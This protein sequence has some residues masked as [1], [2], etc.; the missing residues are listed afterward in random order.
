VSKIEKLTS[1]QEAQIPV[2][3]ERYLNYGLDTSRIDRKKVTPMVA[4]IY[5]SAGL[6]APELIL[7]FD[8][9]ASCLLAQGVLQ[10]V[11]EDKDQLGNQLRNQ[12]IDQLRNQ[13]RN[14]LWN[15]LWDQL[16]DPLRVQLR[17]QLGGQLG[18]QLGDQLRNQLWDQLRVQLR[19][20]LGGQLGNQL[21]DQLRNQLWDQLW[22]PLGDQLWNQLGDPL[23]NQLIDQLRNQ[24]GNQLR[25]QLG[26]PLRNQL[27]NQLRNRFRDQLNQNNTWGNL[28]MFWLGFYAYIHEVLS[29]EGE[30]ISRFKIFHDFSKEVGLWFPYK[31]V[32]IISQKPTEIHMHNDRLHHD[33]GPAIK[34]ADGYSLWALSGIRVSQEIAETP[35]D[36]MQYQM[37]DD[38]QNTEIR[39]LLLAKYGEGRYLMDSGAQETHR[40]KYG[41]LYRR[42]FE[43]DE[44]LVMVR[45]ENS[46]PEPDGTNR[47][48]FLRVN[49]DVQTAHE[50]VAS[51]FGL[52]AEEYD[53]V[54]ES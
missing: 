2:Y 19:D 40:D 45:V 13:R 43:D 51:T 36:K 1:E 31:D 27:R 18:N 29:V 6:K 50:A 41:I 16:G 8:S 12:L 32:C 42:E 9:P 52:T 4:Q 33:G 37:I 7:Y 10:H 22:D 30:V 25:N 17:D 15:Q 53:P 5:E 38:E 14:Q 44:P 23:R 54:V 24:L 34:F 3:F 39:R 11:T 26:D 49:P 20:Q 46:T 21:G 48:Y 47:P 28:D 35:A